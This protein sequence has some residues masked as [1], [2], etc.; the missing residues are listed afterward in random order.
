VIVAHV[1]AIV[2]G[3]VVVLSVLISALETV[4]LPMRGFTRIARFVFAVAYRIL[5]HHWRNRAREI[6]LRGLYGPIALVTLPLVW[7]SLV[8]V[9]FSAIFWG[10]DT[11]TWQHSFEVSGSSL[12]TLGFSA[13][14]GTWRVWLSITEA[15]LGLGLVAL[16]ITYLPTIYAAHHSREKGIMMMRPFAGTPPSPTYMILAFHRLGLIDNEELWR[17]AANWTLE[18]DQTHSD[19]PALCYFPESIPGQSWVATTGCV[20]DAAALL[21]AASDTGRHAA[22]LTSSKG[23]LLVLTFGIPALGHIGKAANLPVEAPERVVDLLDMPAERAGDISIRREEFESALDRLTP[24]LAVG[25]NER[26]ECWRRF[27]A[28]RSGYDRA[29]RGLAGLTLASPAPWTT[30]R[31]ARVGRPRPFGHDPV[32]TDWS[33]HVLPEVADPVA[34][35]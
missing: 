4:V 9:G 12:T 25:T 23:P 28:L 13:P 6:E 8:A 14:V 7:M 10:F 15:I 34:G 31:P 21:L 22:D 17:M 33:I 5:V 19:F 1:V 3:I 35:A 26:D 11:G 24:V 2:V 18:L 29:L 32:S 30:D 27:A 20:L 16:L